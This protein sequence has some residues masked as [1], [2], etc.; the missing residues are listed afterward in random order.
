[1]RSSKIIAALAAAFLASAATAQAALIR[2]DFEGAISSTSAADNNSLGAGL[3]TIAGYV[4]Y[5]TEAAATLFVSNSSRIANN[6]NGAIKEFGFTTGGVSGVK[7]GA[8]GSIQ[9]SDQ[10]TTGSDRLSFNN[11]TLTPADILGES[12]GIANVQFTLGLSGPFSALSSAALPGVFPSSIFTGL[13]NLQV[14]VAL[15]DPASQPGVAKS[16]NFNLTSFTATDVTEVPLP[17]GLALFPAGA[18]L[19]AAARRRKQAAQG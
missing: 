8:F 12:G 4:I 6:Y 15:I 19:L 3:S 10:F 2:I 14:F 16:L 7:S 9:V 13:N 11:M 18:L 1:M 5:D 17:A